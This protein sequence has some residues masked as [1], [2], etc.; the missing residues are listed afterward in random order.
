MFTLLIIRALY[1]GTRCMNFV[2]SFVKG[3]NLRLALCLLFI[4]HFQ[5]LWD[6]D[7][8]LNTPS[9][10]ILFPSY[11]QIYLNL[12]RQVCII[13]SSCYKSGNTVSALP[14]RISYQSINNV[15]PSNLNFAFCWWCSLFDMIRNWSKFLLTSIKSDMI[16][17]IYVWRLI[18]YAMANTTLTVNI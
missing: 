15:L 12:F 4:Y 14:L 2:R 9:W 1:L 3:E 17:L 11:I 10:L 8:Y 5:Y 16:Y 13:R 6:V 18:I 7:A